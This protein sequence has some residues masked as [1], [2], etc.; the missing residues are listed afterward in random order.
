MKRNNSDFTQEHRDDLKA[1]LENDL[2]RPAKASELAN[3]ETDALLLVRRLW[4]RVDELEA[5][6]KK[7]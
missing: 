4:K 6:I 2:G 7:K 1:D 3:G 5:L